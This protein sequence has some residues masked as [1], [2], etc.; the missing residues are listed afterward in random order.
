MC[1]LLCL[2]RKYVFDESWQSVSPIRVRRVRTAKGPPEAYDS[3]AVLASAAVVTS[4]LI[5]ASSS[6]GVS[7]GSDVMAATEVDSGTT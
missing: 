4:Q 7:V 6:A 1:I 3:S 2:L 5:V